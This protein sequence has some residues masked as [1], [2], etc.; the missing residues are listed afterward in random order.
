MTGLEEW[1]TPL[2]NRAT[3]RGTE[4]SGNLTS[5]ARDARCLSAAF[6]MFNFMPLRKMTYLLKLG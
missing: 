2:A 3:D 4:V 5:Q 1:E 6:S